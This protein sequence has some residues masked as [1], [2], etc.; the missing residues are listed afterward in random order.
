M[1]SKKEVAQWW[2]DNPMTYGETHGQSSYG[3]ADYELGTKA[4]FE[5]V[6]REF[7]EWNKPLHSDRPFGKLFP[8]DA[9]SGGKVLEVGCG[10]GT[11]AMNWAQRGAS[12]TAVDLNPVAVE[13]TTKRFELLGLEGDIS[14]A[15]ANGLEFQDENFDYAYSWGVLHHS[16]NL[17][18]SVEEFMRVLKPGGGYGVMLYNRRSFLHWYETLYVEGF[19]HLENRFLDP[20]ALAS[21]YGDGAREEGNPH[22]WPVTVPEMRCMFSKYSDNVNIRILGTDLDYVFR[23]LLPGIGLVIPEVVKKVWARRFGWSVWISGNKR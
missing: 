20:I 4:F 7:Y 22:T 21:R 16:P 15:D 18:K 10:M 3:D 13:Q 5:R 2:A 1:M 11:M 14:V 8:Y 19:L 6:D 9:Y 23:H 12:F 17:D